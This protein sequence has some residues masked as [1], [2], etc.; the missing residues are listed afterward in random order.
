M[1]RSSLIDLDVILLHETDAAVRVSLTEESE[2]VWLPKSQI[3]IYADL[4][5]Y[6]VLPI[7][8]PEPLAVEKGLA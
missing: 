1:T 8:L 4:V 5:P 7:T 2:P 3:E 6:T